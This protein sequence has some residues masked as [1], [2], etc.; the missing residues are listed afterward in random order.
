LNIGSSSS[1]SPMD[2]SC[3]R[4][5]AMATE[6]QKFSGYPLWK[7]TMGVVKGQPQGFRH[8]FDDV[9]C[10]LRNFE[11]WLVESLDVPGLRLWKQTWPKWQWKRQ[12]I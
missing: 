4:T 1:S 7:I 2:R 5:P 3:L 8:M 6:I 9:W 11:A 10:S 12:D